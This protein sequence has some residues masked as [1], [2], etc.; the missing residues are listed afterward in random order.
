M[1]LPYLDL[2]LVCLAELP[3][4]IIAAFIIENKKFG[5]RNS[6]TICFIL[7]FISCLGAYLF[8][9]LLIEFV[10]FGKIAGCGAVK[11]IYPLTAELY[12]TNSR[13]T[14]LGFAGA[15]NKIGGGV[16]PLICVFGFTWGATGPFA[17]FSIIMAIAAVSVFLIP[18]DTTGRGLDILEEK[19]EIEL[20]LL[21]NAK[22]E[23]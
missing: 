18:Y 11:F 3:A 22:T 17:M 12:K 1:G 16:T 15:A 7:M 8:P 14:G 19:N 4:L 23:A 13:T 6:L 10:I 5:R 20:G 2:A 9:S 21:K